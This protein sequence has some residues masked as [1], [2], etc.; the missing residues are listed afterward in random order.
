MNIKAL[1]LEQDLALAEARA[2]HNNAEREGRGLTP[3]EKKQTGALLQSVTSQDAK[4]ERRKADESYFTAL[5]D[6][7]GGS[8]GEPP[9]RNDQRPALRR[10]AASKAQ[11]AMRS[12]P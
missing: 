2:I 6:L 4:I 10:T 8:K 11:I 3:E 5:D 7:V 12:A 9:Y 1:E